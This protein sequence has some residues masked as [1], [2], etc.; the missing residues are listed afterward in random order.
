MQIGAPAGSVVSSARDWA[1]WLLLLA[2]GGRNEG[3]VQV[4]DRAVLGETFEPWSIEGP[5]R[6]SALFNATSE[7]YGLGWYPGFYRGQ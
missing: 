5:Q 1:K 2:S 4:I 6:G 7:T 3:G